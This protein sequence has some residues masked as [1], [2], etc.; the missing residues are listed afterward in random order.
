MS[1][2][3][4]ISAFLVGFSSLIILCYFTER[5][6]FYLL[7][8]LFTVLF[9]LY[10]LVLRKGLF[11]WKHILY[12]GLLL[13]ASTLLMTPNL[14]D[15]YWRFVWDGRLLSSGQNPYLYLPD[16]S[17]GQQEV[18]DLD[19]SGAVYENLN[20]KQYYTIYPPVNQLFFAA[21]AFLGNR[22]AKTEVIVLR[23]LLILFEWGVMLLLVQ[24]LVQLKKPPEL[25]AWYAFNPLVLVEVSGNLHFEGVML[26]FILLSVYLWKKPNHLGG[27]MSFPF[28][29]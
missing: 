10:F 15:D 22:D 29:R 1:L 20:S 27:A 13:R 3:Q 4:R 26:F 24:L 25:M 28:S 8:G 9:S 14:S 6:N 5:S 19:L 7:F 2:L 18:V 17:L 16:E 21:A 23:L 12:V 11:S